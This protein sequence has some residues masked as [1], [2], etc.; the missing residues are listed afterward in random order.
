M[1]AGGPGGGIDAAGAAGHICAMAQDQDRPRFV[2]LHTGPTIEHDERPGSR[3]DAALARVF[4]VSLGI[5]T[6]TGGL[7]LMGIIAAAIVG[8]AFL[9][10]PVALGSALVAVSAYA[11]QRWRAA[12]RARQAAAPA[13]PGAP[14]SSGTAAPPS[15]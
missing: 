8:I 2:F 11:L 6:V 12:M 9:L 13:P 10:V 14:G 1:A 5:A 7:V 15:P 4:L 3:F